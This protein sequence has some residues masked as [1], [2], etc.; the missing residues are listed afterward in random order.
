MSAGSSPETDRLAKHVDQHCAA[1]GAEVAME[2]ADLRVAL[3]GFDERGHARRVRRLLDE[4]GDLL[5]EPSDPLPKRPGLGDQRLRLERAEGVLDEGELA[6]PVPVD[7]ALA[8]AGPSCDRL[9][10][11]RAVA[12]LA[13]LV[14]RGLEDHA[15][16][17]A[18]SAGPRQSATM[19]ILTRRR[20]RR[21]PWRAPARTSSSAI[22]SI[23]STPSGRLVRE[24]NHDSHRGGEDDAD[25][26]D[27]G[28]VEGVGEGGSRPAL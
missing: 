5:E 25:R 26:D 12:D 15:D 8:D 17:S 10:R 18:R 14:E 2:G 28:D 20:R 27:A 3:G 11:Q 13:Q 19:L 7:R 1:L 22:S 4:L 9:D 16:A 24:K 21:E 6:R 23:S